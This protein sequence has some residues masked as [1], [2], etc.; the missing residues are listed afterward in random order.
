MPSGLRRRRIERRFR[1][2]VEVLV[3]YNAGKLR[4]KF[5]N[6]I[7]ATFR[8]F[9]RSLDQRLTAAVAAT[10]GAAQA[11]LKKRETHAGAVAADLRSLQVTL[12]TLAGI[13]TRLG[14]VGP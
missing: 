7:D 1:N 6:Q 14:N 5:Y 8:R 12:G 11:A 10:H 2:K 3:L 9:R 13:A 4:E